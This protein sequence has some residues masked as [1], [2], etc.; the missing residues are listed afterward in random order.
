MYTHTQSAT[1]PGV[2]LTST[3]R[4]VCAQAFP[5]FKMF[6]PR[7]IKSR[8]VYII[9]AYANG[10]GLGPADRGYQVCTPFINPR[11]ACARVAV[12]GTRSVCPS[13]CPSGTT[14]PGTTS[15]GT[16][17]PATTRNGTSNRRNLRLRRNLEN[18]LNMAFS[19]FVRYGVKKPTCLVCAYRDII[20]P[21]WS[22]IS[23]EISKTGPFLVLSKSIGRLQATW[24]I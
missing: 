1:P 19:R 12:L 7:K 5:D 8:Y 13:V 14:S 10:E 24:H 23:P 17:S 22:D 20:W 6:H 15:P 21:R 4:D 2:Y 9:S 18:I 3:S 11:R 16:T